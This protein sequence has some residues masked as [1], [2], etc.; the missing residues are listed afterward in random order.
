MT[1]VKR[2]VFDGIMPS[3]VNYIMYLFDYATTNQPTVSVGST[4]TQSTLFGR[5]RLI[6]LAQM[7]LYIEPRF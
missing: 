6:D 4:G 7:P 1:L 3:N 5:V 2:F